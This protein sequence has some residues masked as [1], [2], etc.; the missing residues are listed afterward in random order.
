MITPILMIIGLLI[1]NL[2]LLVITRWDQDYQWEN[3]QKN[4]HRMQDDITQIERRVK[5]IQWYLADDE[6][7]VPGLM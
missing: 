1:I 7:D 4:Q 2:I 3:L 6:D 5:A